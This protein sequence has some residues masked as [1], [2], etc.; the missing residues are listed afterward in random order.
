MRGAGLRIARGGAGRSAAALLWATAVLA[1]GCGRLGFEPQSGGDAGGPGPDGT[2]GSDAGAGGDAAAAPDCAAIASPGGLRVHLP[3]DEGTGPIA[4]DQS[5]NGNDGQLAGATWG[6]GS[7]GGA[8]DLDGQD[9]QVDL[10]SAASV[11]DLTPLTMCAWINPR[12]YPDQ[13]PAIADKST[14]TFVGGWNFYIEDNAT[15]GLLAH[16]RQWAT[17]GSIELDRWQH[18]C[19]SWDGSDG[20]GGIRLH[21]DGAPIA[22]TSSGSNGNRTDSD[23]GHD[24]LIGRVNNGTFP[25]D[26]RIDEFVLY[27]GV[28]DDAAI[29][30]IFECAGLGTGAVPVGRSSDEALDPGG[31]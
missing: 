9:D 19:A 2:A 5:G 31:R 26:G 14:D 22:T 23:A 15:F 10:G 7:L 4:G 16:N 27:Q 28:L 3:F 29:R 6:A 11:D 30:D 12:S 20:A 18:L 1:S 8:V 17:G 13:F 21:Q 24:L 25:F